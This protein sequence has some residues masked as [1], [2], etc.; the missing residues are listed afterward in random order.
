MELGIIFFRSQLCDSWWEAPGSQTAVSGLPSD[1]AEGSHGSQTKTLGCTVLA[2]GD[3]LKSDRVPRCRGSP[4]PDPDDMAYLK[5]PPFQP[6]PTALHLAVGQSA[7]AQKAC[8]LPTPCHVFSLALYPVCVS[9]ALLKA[10]PCSLHAGSR[11]KLE[12]CLQLYTRLQAR[13]NTPRFQLK[14][15]TNPPQICST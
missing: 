1:Q 3:W 8:W 5:L 14:C 4:L 12:R 13:L 2:P 10:L 7:A 11:A 6:C 9:L 15:P